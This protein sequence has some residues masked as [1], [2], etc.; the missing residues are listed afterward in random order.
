MSNSWKNNL[1]AVLFSNVLSVIENFV[2]IL[3]FYFSQHSN[4]RFSLPV[5]V[6]VCL[7]SVIGSIMRIAGSYVFRRQRMGEYDIRN[8]NS[9]SVVIMC[10][11][12]AG[13]CVFLRARTKELGSESEISNN[14]SAPAEIIYWTSSV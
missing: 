7:F 9:P 2:M 5:T 11:S 4:S 8:N 13:L 10:E 1:L 3:M 12:I 14:N 6:C